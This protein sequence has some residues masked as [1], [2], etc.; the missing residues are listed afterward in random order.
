M[1]ISNIK[2]DWGPILEG[3][4]KYLEETYPDIA[5]R[6]SFR[7]I[8]SLL[9]S[10]KIK[11]RV[12]LSGINVA[13]YGFVM[14]SQHLDDRIYGSLGFTDPSFASETR[15]K[16]LIDWAENIASSMKRYLMINEIFNSESL[17][18]KYL[19]DHGYAK[20]RRDA[21]NISLIDLELEPEKF[22]TEFEIAEIYGTTYQ[23]YAKAEYAAYEGSP[24]RILFHTASEMDRFTLA[25]SI[26]D[27]AYGDLIP[28]ASLIVRHHGKLIGA[29][30]AT[31]KKTSG[32][33]RGAL[34]ADI[35][36][37]RDY[38]GNGLGTALMQNSLFPENRLA[39]LTHS[40]ER[41]STPLGVGAIWFAAG[42]LIALGLVHSTDVLA[43][44]LFAVTIG[45]PTATMIG[46]RLG[47]HKLPFNHKKSLAGFLGILSFSSAFGY[48]LLGID[49]IVLGVVSAL[50]ES[51]S[52]YPLDDNF[53]IPVV[54]G[55]VAFLF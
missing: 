50:V 53:M 37:D 42:T 44:I 46:S 21:M 31:K 39:R 28:S 24:D 9:N 51:L 4:I 34:I 22:P 17:G 1:E 7:G 30:L 29:V 13:A 3:Q 45:D 38:R 32:N 6:E 19:L 20:H 15:L 48:L 54:M 47:S 27:G 40:L 12:I 36:V 14:E 16:N 52:Y 8:I 26:F 43:V 18:E 49:G 11:S 10:N 5:I 25:K 2:I 55:I 33:S 35:F 23:E 41:P